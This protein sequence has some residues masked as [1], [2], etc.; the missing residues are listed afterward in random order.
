MKDFFL[1]KF[2]GKT[3]KILC[4]MNPKHEEFVVR[5]GNTRVLYLRLTKALYGCVKSALLVWYELF[6][7]ILEELRY[8]LNPHDKCVA[9]C[10]ID[11]K[12]CTIAWYKDDMKILHTDPKS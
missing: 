6:S 11:G 3:V 2:T 5:E 9:N 10:T 8:V 12:Q 4:K 7:S 1:R